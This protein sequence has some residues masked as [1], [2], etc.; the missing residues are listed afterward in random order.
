[1]RI[2]TRF[3]CNFAQLGIL[4]VHQPGTQEEPIIITLDSEDKE[5]LVL[6]PNAACYYAKNRNAVMI[7]LGNSFED[8]LREVLQKNEDEPVHFYYGLSGADITIK[9]QGRMLIPDSNKWT[10]EEFP[11]AK[12]GVLYP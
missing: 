5:A 7:V 11:D 10:E 2:F 8:Y 12:K 6:L 9:N 1:M 3:Q 4:S